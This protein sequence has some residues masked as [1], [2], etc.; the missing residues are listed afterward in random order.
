MAADTPSVLETR[1]DQ[2]F[3]ILSPEEIA[4][5]RNFGETRQFKS[6]EY[7]SRTGERSPGMLVILSGEVEATQHDALGQDEHIIT[8]RPGSFSAELSLLSGSPALV[9]AVAKGD[10][11]A[12]VIP[13]QKLR[14][15]MV[16]EAELGER[17]M[18]ALILRRM[19]LL[20]TGHS[21]PVIVGNDED[22]NVL[23]LGDFL[24]RNGHPHQILDPEKD[25]AAKVLI[26]RFDGAKGELPLV[27]CPAGQVLHN[28]SENELATCLGLVQP[29][30][31]T[32]L[33]DVA[34]VGAG[35]AG[36]AA[37]VY[38]ASEGLEVLVL[39]CRAF[40]GQAG[41]SARIENYLGFPTG[42]SGL[43]L[44]GRAY[45]QAQ[46]FGAHFS[47]PNEAV[48]LREAEDGFFVETADDDHAHVR[49]VVLA[50]GARYRRPNIPNLG[51]FEGS[52]VHYWASALEAKL[53]AGEE[54][55]LVGAGNSA[56]QAAV[57]LSGRVEKVWLLMRGKNLRKTMSEY[58]VERI[59]AQQNIEVLAET[60]ISGLDGKDGKLERVRWRHKS[61]GKES[62]RPIR[63]V[64]LFI[65]ADPN[66]DWLK[67]SGIA[68]DEKGFIRTGA[69]CGKHHPALQTNRPG[70]FAIGDVRSG[71]IKR[72][73]A[74]V[75]EGAQVVAALH[76]HLA[77]LDHPS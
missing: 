34:I 68:L 7:L 14:D 52:H 44:T 21:G 4:R 5:L 39:D 12:L 36:L 1:R 37:A 17:I 55:V 41:A 26:D 60:E 75:G 25:E 65:G 77:E 40:G 47:I 31:S 64:F 69:E 74:A 63:H 15:L 38:A 58:L 43:A 46:K 51:E 32:K 27:F 73:A 9:N 50:T 30:D 33:Y 54:V 3:P 11:E 71:S 56:G 70:V 53:C 72:V 22:R 62:E 10:V 16:E 24:R 42:I 20:E 66:T 57:F 45:N 6:G 59:S 76:I 18:R 28:P 8:H 23:R 61:S 35:P 48:H 19:G 2:V 29:I 67:P 49:S 13:P